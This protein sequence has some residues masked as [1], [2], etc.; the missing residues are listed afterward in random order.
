MSA[1]TDGKKTT[2]SRPFDDAKKDDP[3]GFTFMVMAQD[4]FIE[5]KATY[6]PRVF[7]LSRS[8]WGRKLV[9]SGPLGKFAGP[10]EIGHIPSTGEFCS[11]TDHVSLKRL[12]LAKGDLIQLIIQHHSMLHGYV[13]PTVDADDV[14]TVLEVSFVESH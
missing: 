5:L 2:F 7:G 4:D 10:V 8:V 1:T 6:R 3:Q 12:G 13:M 11:S 14:L 9:G